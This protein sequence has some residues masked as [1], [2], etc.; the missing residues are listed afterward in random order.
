MKRDFEVK[1][2][3]FTIANYTPRNN[4]YEKGLKYQLFIKVYDGAYC[5]KNGHETADYTYHA[6]GYKS[7]SLRDCKKYALE[8]YWTW[9]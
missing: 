6:T 9:I 7:H 4:E 5:I 1:G 2:V 3:E 8:N